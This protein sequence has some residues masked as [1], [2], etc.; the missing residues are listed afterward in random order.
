MVVN[1]HPSSWPTFDS[2]VFNGQ[3]LNALYLNG[4]NL[5]APFG[6]EETETRAVSS[7]SSGE[8]SG[9]TFTVTP[10]RNVITISFTFRA[11][12]ADTYTLK[13]DGVAY[14]G[15]IPIAADGYG[16]WTFE[17]DLDLGVE[18]TFDIRPTDGSNNEYY[19]GNGDGPTTTA[20]FAIGAWQ[21]A[22]FPDHAPYF[23]LT[24]REKI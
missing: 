24:F 23:D 14:G 16:T 9:Q 2:V 4:K 10:N 22:S 1:Q 20:T 6:P 15:D 8:Y 7:T 11:H 21:N 5:F 18:Y 17:V 3:I 19:F 12:W 13:I